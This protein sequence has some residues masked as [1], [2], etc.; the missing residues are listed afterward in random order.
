MLR[1]AAVRYRKTSL[2]LMTHSG[3]SGRWTHSLGSSRLHL[4][5][6][7]YGGAWHQKERITR[8]LGIAGCSRLTGAGEEARLFDALRNSGLTE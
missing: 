5:M 3:H 4:A 1:K 2:P 7:E 6:Q 8:R